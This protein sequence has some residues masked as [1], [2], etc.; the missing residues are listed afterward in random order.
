MLLEE[1][2]KVETKYVHD[3]EGELLRDEEHLR[4]TWVRFYLSLLTAKSD[5]LELGTP[6]RLPE[7][8]IASA[9]GTKSTEKGAATA[10]KAMTK[11]ESSGAG[12][13][14]RRTIDTRTSTRPDRPTGA[15][16]I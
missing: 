10:M 8:P 1:I 5:M 14:F 9:L 4:G 13:P 12:W 2:I 7:Q 11:S 15:S 6:K 3:E 16:A